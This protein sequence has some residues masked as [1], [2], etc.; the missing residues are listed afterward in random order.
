MAITAINCKVLFLINE[1][2]I[3]GS[4]KYSLSFSNSYNEK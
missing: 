3:D 1:H 4:I 2:D